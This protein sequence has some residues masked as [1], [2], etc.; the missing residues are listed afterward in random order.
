M[1]K[2]LKANWLET[3]KEQLDPKLTQQIFTSDNVMVVYYIYEA[4][5]EFQ[6]HSHPQEQITIIQSGRLLLDIDGEKVELKKGDICAIAPNVVHSTVV[7]GDER[8]ESISIFTPIAD[9]V[10]IND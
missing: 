8:V 4:G 9:R 6:R 3:N 7:I 2:Y 10:I 5:L 1:K